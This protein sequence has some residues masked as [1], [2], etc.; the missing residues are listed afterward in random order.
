MRP[1]YPDTHEITLYDSPAFELVLLPKFALNVECGSS[2]TGFASPADDYI[3]ATLDLNEWH[4][5]RRHQCFL[6]SAYGQSMRDA[7]IEEGDLLIVDTS[8][9]YRPKDIV[10]CCLNGSYKAKI[11][12]QDRGRFYLASR[13]PLFKSI[14]ISE[15]DDVTVFGVV[16]GLSRKFR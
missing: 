3:E 2:T 12:M 4:G 5:I 15:Q 11:I 13:N 16:S 8:L 1:F 7:G 10:I 14:E 9:Q 6:V